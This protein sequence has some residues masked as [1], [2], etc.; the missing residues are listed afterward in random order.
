[1]MRTSTHVPLGRSIDAANTYNLRPASGGCICAFL[2]AI[3]QGVIFIHI[4]TTYVSSSTLF[5]NLEA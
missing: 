1:M 4:H 3:A 5:R 2:R